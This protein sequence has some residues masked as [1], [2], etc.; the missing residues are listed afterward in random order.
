MKRYPLVA[1]EWDDTITHSGW[2]DWKDLKDCIIPCQSVGWKIK[3]DRRSITLSAM[4]SKDGCAARQVI[5]MG[6]I[7]SIRELDE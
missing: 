4:K 3:S 6:C 1:I 5:P 2:I 7:R